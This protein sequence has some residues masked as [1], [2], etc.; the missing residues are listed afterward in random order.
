MYLSKESFDVGILGRVSFSDPCKVSGQET[1]C[2]NEIGLVEV[3]TY[4]EIFKNGVI[5][6][7]SLNSNQ[8]D[9]D[10]TSGRDDS[11]DSYMKFPRPVSPS[12][13]VCR[14]SFQEDKSL[15]YLY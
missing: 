13:S 2:S 14:I 11:H 7:S 5:S 15:T 10:Y 3:D 6:L 12:Y 4:E 1:Y 8:K 9:T